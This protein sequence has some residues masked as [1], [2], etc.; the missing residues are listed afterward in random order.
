MGLI[1]ELREWFRFAFR[2][3]EA[4][5]DIIFFS[6]SASYWAYFEGLVHGLKNQSQ[7]PFCYVTSDPNDPRLSADDPQIRAFYL[8]QLLPFFMQFVKCRAFVMT[9]TEL[10]LHHIKRSVNPVHYVYAFHSLNS[11]HMAYQP[12]AFDHYD[13]ILCCGP[14]MVQ[15]IESDEQLRDLPKKQLIE[16]GYYRVERIR[17]AAQER[18]AHSGSR[19]DSE[20]GQAKTNSTD[21]GCILIAPSWAAHNVLEEHGIEIAE[22]LLSV[23]HEVILRPHPE[24]IKRSPDVV[25]AFA[26]HFKDNP[27]LIVERSVASDDSLLRAD[28][29]I[30]DWSGIAQE[31]AFGTER[32]VLYLDVPRKVHNE[33]YESLEI[34]PFEAQIRN[35]VGVVLP[36]EEISQINQAVGRLMR[37]RNAYGDRIRA[38][39]DENLFCFGESG[40]VGARHILDVVAKH[41]GHDAGKCPGQNVIHADRAAGGAA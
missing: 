29:L 33:G 4:E 8:N 1:G 12:R 26:R 15:E 14:Y 2:T 3:P 31:Y 10:D 35:E 25:D 34:E 22:R 16:A 20:T 13:S 30:T 40:E 24:T 41:A 17:R 27:S 5:K 9:L 37:D 7:A 19:I 38:L 18:S 23:G 28:I 11:T 21:T 32:P 39:R 6:E 36:T